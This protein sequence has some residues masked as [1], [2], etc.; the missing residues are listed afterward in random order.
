MFYMMVEQQ[1]I[2]VIAVYVCAQGK[3]VPAAAVTDGW[4][5]Q[6]LC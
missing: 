6:L 3:D 1:L 4:R 2:E 5:R